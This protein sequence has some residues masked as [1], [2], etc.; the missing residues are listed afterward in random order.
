MSEWWCHEARGFWVSQLLVTPNFMHLVKVG[1]RKLWLMHGLDGT[2]D[3]FSFWSNI[4]STVTTAVSCRLAITLVLKL[5]PHLSSVWAQ[6]YW[7]WEDK[8]GYWSNN[9]SLDS[10]EWSVQCTAGIGGIW[11]RFKFTVMCLDSSHYHPI[12]PSHIERRELSANERAYASAF[13]SLRFKSWRWTPEWGPFK[14]AYAS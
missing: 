3:I 12:A 8:S 9:V 14:N 4:L 5:T 13:I 2:W 6:C 7:L 11:A 1:F 10:S